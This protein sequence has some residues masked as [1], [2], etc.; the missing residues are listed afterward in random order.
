MVIFS[1]LRNF[2]INGK[3]T[4]DYEKCLMGTVIEQVGGR[5][6]HTSKQKIEITVVSQ[7]RL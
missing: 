3:D 5:S 2:D 7:R 4:L 6:N 1:Y